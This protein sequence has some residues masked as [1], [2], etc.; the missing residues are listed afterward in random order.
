MLLMAVLL[1]TTVACG[2]RLNDAQYVEARGAG[3]GGGGA[4]TGARTSGATASAGPTAAG[5]T[6][7]DPTAAAD[8]SGGDSAAAA[9]GGGPAACTPQ[10]SDAPG[11][12]DSEIKL[13]N[14]STISGPVPNFGA[15]GRAGAKAYLDYVNAQG[16][17]CGRKLSLVNGDDRLDPGLNRSQTDQM[18]DSVFGFVGNTTVE[19]DGGAGVIGGTNV[20][21]CSLIIGSEA[22]KQPNFYSPNP[23]DPS[24]N[25]NGTTAI[26]SWLKANK[27][28]TKVGIVYPDNPNAAAR[29]A[30]YQGDIA[31]AGLTADP[32]IKVSV[33][34]SNYVGV[35]SQ[36]KNAGDDSFITVLE[37]NGI[38]KLAQAI[39]QVGWQPKAPYYGAQA[40]GPQLPQLAGPAA[41]GALIGLTHDIV[42]GGGPAMQSMAQFYQASSSGQPLDFFA[43]MGWGAAKLCVDA[44]AAAGPAPTRDAAI[45]ALNTQTNFTADDLLAP[46][47]PA[48]KHSPTSFVMVT[49]EGGHW[50]RIYPDAGFATG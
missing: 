7:G 11:V 32:I 46:R 10:H 35:A 39:Q 23:I 1:L 40:Y 17:V 5:A 44:I 45:A 27:G 47:D 50:K 48:G 20:P 6:G 4:A 14:V 33:T 2:A 13:G 25:T 15:T 8:T 9:G 31:A 28:I 19:D 3:N 43:I 36:M 26:W 38:S 29:I 37:V 42:E 30:G 22:L 49:I 41:D 34:E 21:N 16:G 24:G 12:S 18:K